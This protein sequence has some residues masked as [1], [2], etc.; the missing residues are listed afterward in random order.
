M[1]QLSEQEQGWTMKQIADEL[2][3][4]KMRVYRTISR[5]NLTEAFKRGQ[6]LYFNQDAKDAIEQAINPTSQSQETTRRPT[7]ARSV[8]QDYVDN[9]LLQSLNDRV[10]DQQ[11]Q[12]TNLTRLLDQSQRLQLVAEQR[13]QKMEQQITTLQQQLAAPSA[14]ATLAPENQANGE[15]Q[16]L[17][18]DYFDKAHRDQNPA[19][20]KDESTIIPK[21]EKQD[22]GFF[23]H[24]WQ[25]PLL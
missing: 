9:G 14:V 24:F 4:N 18:P 6:T 7:Q 11:T 3:V 19:D 12:I 20:S 23:K 5:L 22:G 15:R 17:D 10:K 1:I 13:S 2:G 25:K 8:S 21:P 16:Q